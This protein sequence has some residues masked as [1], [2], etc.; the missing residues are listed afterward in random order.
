M[1]RVDDYAFGR[2]VV[3][4]REEHTDVILLPGRI[5]SRWWRRRGH[6]LVIEDLA[7]VLPE[8]PERLVIGTG[9]EGRMHADPVALERLAALG[10]AVEVL[11]TPQAVR[12]YRELDPKHTAAALHLTC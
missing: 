4:G 1:A 7:E 6:E 10:V 9:M 3:D 11:P 8:L 2:I 5:V 12:R